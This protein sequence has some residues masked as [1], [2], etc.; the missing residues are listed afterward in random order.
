MYRRTVYH[1]VNLIRVQS[2]FNAAARLVCRAS[3]YDHVTRIC[4]AM[5]FTGFVA[6]SESLSDYVCTNLSTT[7]CLVTDKNS[8]CRSTRRFVAQHFGR[9]LMLN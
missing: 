6:K 2:V 3:R 5:T 9:H 4:A 8:V 7:K 1:H